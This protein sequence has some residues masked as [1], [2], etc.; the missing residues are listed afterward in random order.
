MTKE[1]KDSEGTLLKNNDILLSSRT[2]SPVKYKFCNGRVYYD[3][4]FKGDYS[5]EYFI[6]VIR[7]NC[8]KQN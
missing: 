6:T 2:H 1:Y 3:G 5:F 7:P 8:V 4:L